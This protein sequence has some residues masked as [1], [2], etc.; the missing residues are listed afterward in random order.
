MCLRSLEL[1]FPIL[2]FLAL[3]SQVQMLHKAVGWISKPWI[4]ARSRNARFRTET[5]GLRWDCC[6]NFRKQLR[7]C[8]RAAWCN[9][10]LNQS[11]SSSCQHRKSAL[12]AIQEIQGIKGNLGRSSPPLKQKLSEY[13]TN[14]IERI[15][16]FYCSPNC[17]FTPLESRRKLHPGSLPLLMAIATLCCSTSCRDF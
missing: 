8:V 15:K 12:L 17:V 4:P 1:A 11:W 14:C 6:F 16:G 3:K 5:W 10:F 9:L 13:S 2:Q 7:L